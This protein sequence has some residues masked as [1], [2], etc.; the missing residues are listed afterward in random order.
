MYKDLIMID[1]NCSAVS[2]E[3]GNIRIVKK[4]SDKI[5]FLEILNAE[6]EIENIALDIEKYKKEISILEHKKEKI[7]LILMIPAVSVISMFILKMLPPLILL[8]TII[9]SYILLT[10]V[11]LQKSY[12]KGKKKGILAKIKLLNQK[13]NELSKK[14]ENIKRQINYRTVNKTLDIKNLLEELNTDNFKQSETILSRINAI[15]KENIPEVISI[16]SLFENRQAYTSEE[17]EHI[18]KLS[19]NKRK[20]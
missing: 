13:E 20:K 4:D 7:D 2:D 19:L 17:N 16:P 15:E 6:N 3:N 9:V 5:N 8:Y 1:K 10:P 14:L 11:Y 18:K 12:Y